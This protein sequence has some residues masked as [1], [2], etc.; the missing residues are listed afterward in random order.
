M[1]SSWPETRKIAGGRRQIKQ[2][3]CDGGDLLAPCWHQPSGEPR[4]PGMG[5]RERSL[6]GTTNQRWDGLQLLRPAASGTVGTGWAGTGE[7]QGLLLPDLPTPAPL[8]HTEAGL[9]LQRPSVGAAVC[10]PWHSRAHAQAC[11]RVYG[12]GR[13]LTFVGERPPTGKAA[14]WGTPQPGFLP[15]PILHCPP[16][17]EPPV[18]TFGGGGK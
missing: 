5:Q 7:E 17:M 15:F 16:R 3:P 12:A 6:L 4:E 8:P 2:P 9:C 1:L 10:K 11:T 13:V 18:V 14:T